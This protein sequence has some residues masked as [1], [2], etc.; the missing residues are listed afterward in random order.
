MVWLSCFWKREK[1]ER[2]VPGKGDSFPR[3]YLAAIASCPKLL[4]RELY[5]KETGKGK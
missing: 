5:V 1:K 2:A 3:F 4:D